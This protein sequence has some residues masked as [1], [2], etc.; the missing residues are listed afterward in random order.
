MSDTVTMKR[1]T[2][3]FLLFSAISVVIFLII[4]FIMLSAVMRKKSETTL[5]SV[6]EIYM[7]GINEQL[8]QKFDILMDME[9]DQLSGVIKRT[10]LL[11]NASITAIEED[12]ILNAQIRGFTFLGMYRKDGTHKI[13]YGSES[14][15][16]PLDEDEF[17]LMLNDR[18]VK[19]SYGETSSGERI[20]LLGLEALY[21][22]EDGGYSDVLI[23]G[24]STEYLKESLALDEESSDL[25]SHI[26]DSKGR[27]VIRSGDAFRDSYFERV[28]VIYSP[29]NGKNVEQYIKEIEES[30]KKQK[31]YS[32]VM[33]NK[34][35]ERF[36][37]YLSM[38]DDTSW[39]LLSVLPFGSLDAATNKLNADRFS[40][41]LTSGIIMFLIFLC[42]FIIY[43]KMSHDQLETLHQA[44]QEAVKANQA[45][46]EF[47]S[48]MSH[49][50]RTPMNGIVGMTAIAQANINDRDR[51]TD[52]LSKISL[53]SKHLL[54][55][56]N[57][58]LDMSKIESGKLSLNTHIVSLRETMDNLVNIAQPQIKAKNQAFDIFIQ[59][60][61]TENVYCDSV[62]LNQILL[63]LL[64]NAIKFTPEHGLIHVYLRQ[65]NSPRG[66]NFIRCVFTVRDNGIGMTE[67]FQKQIFEKFSREQTQQVHKTEGSGLGMA[68][69][70]AIVDA[71]QGTI[72]LKSKLGEGTEFTVTFDLECADVQEIDMVLPPWK[73]LVVDDDED[74][75]R[76]TVNALQ[77]IGIQAEWAT[78]GH[79]AIDMALKRHTMSDDYQIILL[80]WRM[81]DMNG[82]EIAKAFRNHLGDTVPILIISAYDWN[83][84]ESEA[85]QAG[86]QGFISKPLFKSN[87]FL[88][89]SPYIL[90]TKKTETAQKE[91]S[92]QFKGKHILLAEDN[93]LNWEIANELLSEEG[94]I[95]ERAEN[96]LECVEM[97]SKSEIG[98]YDAILMDIQMPVMNG[99]DA[100]KNIRALSRSD[101]NIPIIAITAD[102]FSDD[103]QRCKDCGMNEHISKPIDMEQLMQTLSRYL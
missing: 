86:V 49:D 91:K 63:N 97:F 93:D 56:I 88:G 48:S 27:F 47:L 41:M 65:E 73:M 37:I 90:E 87:L 99:Y 32:T 18:N 23:A 1:Q 39:A 6:T 45:K 51:V 76:S 75:C 78:S 89:L 16:K 84:I 60:I 85:R 71:M 19:M 44:E 31:D 52:C 10:S 72:E 92:D 36:N 30:F 24:I 7:E 28:R 13:L 34:D 20:L 2:N 61:Q 25:V 69:T 53:S 95:V 14:V 57:D 98:Q 82:L 21:P 64:S 62:R 79:I 59:N 12:L 29:Y 102:A 94:F 68:I 38:I 4:V 3:R 50:I 66:K 33:Q 43:Y 46:S 77:E 81:P 17:K 5:N 70:K 22:M 42:I 8:R 26:I 40:V 58:V 11:T 74:L 83:D 80:D 9:L 15:P 35:G 54:G 103:I 101:S 55:L 67:D 100:A 96:G